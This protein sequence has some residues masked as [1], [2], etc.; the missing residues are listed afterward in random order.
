MTLGHKLK[1][2]LLFSVLFLTACAACR[3]QNPSTENSDSLIIAGEPP[4]YSAMVVRLVEAGEQKEETTT[5]VVC[6]GEMRREEWTEASSK[7]AL[8]FRP[9]LGKSFLLDLDQRVYVETDLAQSSKKKDANKPAAQTGALAQPAPESETP[10]A[11][12]LQTVTEDYL[13]SDFEE[14]PATLETHA[15]PDAEQDGRPL[16][17]IEQKAT[18]AGGRVE[19]T[20]I[21]RA[22]SLNGLIVKTE[23]E[24]LSPRIKVTTERRDI[25]LDI[26]AE[27]FAVPAGFKKVE[28]LVYR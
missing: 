15:L 10:A 14:E 20:R 25:K 21:F 28:R 5:R 11:T 26:S 22:E 1:C 23:M 12:S 9:D 4:N 7:R 3:Q 24:S 17:V 18:F 19:T 8:I 13:N 16:K 2:A 6:S 27:E